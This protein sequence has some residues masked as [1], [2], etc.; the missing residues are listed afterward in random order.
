MTRVLVADD[1]PMFRSSVVRAIGMHPE[2]ELVGE[3]SDGRE[4]LDALR[5]LT[6]EVAVVDVQMPGLSGL[7]L[8]DAVRVERLATRVLVLSGALDQQD[9]Y[10]AVQLGAAG[11]LSKLVE[12]QVLTDAIAAIARGETVL[13]VEAQAA[14]ATEIQMREVDD[15][16]VLTDREREVLTRIADGES[17][18]TMAST[19]Y[20][21]RSTIK[22]HLE[23]LYRKL[24]VSDRAAAV[25]EAMRRGILR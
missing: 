7:D 11:V 17:V 13:G 23:S 24:G 2:L 16:P 10:R 20:L 15:R 21:S 3:A 14:V 8:L 6:P 9:A 12:P 4:A 5:S 18:P 19:M 25:A 1:H 22:T